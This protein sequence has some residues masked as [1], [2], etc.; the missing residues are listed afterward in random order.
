MREWDSIRA[1]H[2]A[3]ANVEAAIAEVMG[4]AVRSLRR[5]RHGTGRMLE[6][7]RERYRRGL[8]STEPGM[9]GLLRAQVRWRSLR[10]PRF[11]KGD[12]S[13][14]RSRIRPRMLR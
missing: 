9:L 13:T 4:T 12:I 14:Y 2:V 8:A 6:V 10:M 7:F 1:L 11:G 5:S 3:E